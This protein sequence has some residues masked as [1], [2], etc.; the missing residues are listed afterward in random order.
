M[1]FVVLAFVCPLSRYCG[2]K[3]HDRILK[4]ALEKKARR[5]WRRRGQRRALSSNIV[6]SKFI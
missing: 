3:I 5:H 4:V 1:R 6:T 2:K